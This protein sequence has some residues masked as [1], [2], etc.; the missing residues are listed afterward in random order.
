M[1][2]FWT[3]NSRASRTAKKVDPVKKKRSFERRTGGFE[4]TPVFRLWVLYGWNAGLVRFESDETDLSCDFSRKLNK[5]SGCLTKH[6][7][8]SWLREALDM[9][10][11]FKGDWCIWLPTLFL[12][13]SHKHSPWN[14]IRFFI[15]VRL[16][17][18]WLSRV[19][20]KPWWTKWVNNWFIGMKG[21]LQFAANLYGA[22]LVVYQ[23]SGWIRDGYLFERIEYVFAPFKYAKTSAWI[24]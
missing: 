12:D 18:L 3:I 14:M 20:P 22:N 7:P 2:D 23:S 13:W 5:K 8:N 16:A 6:L 11:G 4:K 17:I 1:Q 19:E 24:S 10:Y 15:W 9:S 21:T